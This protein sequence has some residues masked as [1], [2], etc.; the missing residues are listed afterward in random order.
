M[1]SK[2]KEEHQSE[3]FPQIEPDCNL[4]RHYDDLSKVATAL[5][6]NMATI[7]NFAEFLEESTPL[8]KSDVCIHGNIIIGGFVGIVN[9]NGEVDLWSSL[10]EDT[11]KLRKVNS[12]DAKCLLEHFN[13][14]FPNMAHFKDWH[15]ANVLNISR[16]IADTLYILARSKN[17]GVSPTCPVC[18]D[19]RG[20]KLSVQKKIPGVVQGP[21]HEEH[22]E[23]RADPIVVKAL[24][25]HLNELRELYK[26]LLSAMPD[27]VDLFSNPK[28]KDSQ[29]QNHLY[30]GVRYDPLF[31]SLKSHYPD[32][33]FWQLHSQFEAQFK[34]YKDMWSDL[35][36]DIIKHGSSWPNT[37]V[38]EH[39]TNP[40]YDYI[41]FSFV[42]SPDVKYT[43]YST[44]LQVTVGITDDKSDYLVLSHPIQR[45]E[46]Y[47]LR[48]QDLLNTVIADGWVTKL[49]TLHNELNDK[50]D[51]I[52]S[53]IKRILLRRDYIQYQCDLCPGQNRTNI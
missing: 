50:V 49:K 37:K 20:K 25:A 7:L 21:E 29:L 44:Q 35:L 2:A 28:S 19:V 34:E 9:A 18:K 1:V 48:Y 36:N 13:D 30:N 43:E 22:V 40:I 47:K 31:E 5:A 42:G 6:D 32:N 11:S 41:I 33:A 39:F 12:L 23:K 15:E 24:E 3:S 10:D 17:F 38:T 51:K 53:T 27:G 4:S 8:D 26:S 45:P 16:D 46:N 52:D 14:R